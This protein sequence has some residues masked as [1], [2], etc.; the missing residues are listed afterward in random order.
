M[1]NKRVKG[2]LLALFSAGLWA[3]IGVLARFIYSFGAD[4]LFVVTAR[5][6]FAAVLSFIGIGLLNPKALK[7]Q[8][9]QILLCMC[10]GTIAIGANFALYFYA[11]KF[12]TIPIAVTLI[13]T[14]PIFVIVLSSL[15]F[16]EK[17][18]KMHLLASTLL[19][20]GIWCLVGAPV[21]FV[22][23]EN[24]QGAVFAFGCA[25][26]IGVYNVFGKRLL[27]R[28]PPWSILTYALLGGSVALLGLWST[29]SRSLPKLSFPAWLSIFLLAVGPTILG[30]GLYLKAIENIGPSTSA[31]LA[32][33][34]PLFATLLAWVIFRERITMVQGVGMCIVLLG[35]SL[36]YIGRP[37]VKS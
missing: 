3:N 5:A 7:L 22:S 11:I 34:E 6:V 1:G 26:T 19:L 14:N 25:L 23:S 21:T 8:P 16:R 13:Y 36:T 35:A 32:T 30:Y 37:V 9:W 12:T 17:L 29:I 27:T 33:T 15:F 31:I 18:Q 24:L 20:V 28:I 2:A 10:Y 4:P